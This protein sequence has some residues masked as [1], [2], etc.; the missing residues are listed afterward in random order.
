MKNESK[1]TLQHLLSRLDS[2]SREDIFASISKQYESG[3]SRVVSFLY[4]ASIAEVFWSQ[5][6]EKPLPYLASLSKSDYILPD[7]IALA[8]LYE[9]VIRAQPL[10]YLD[11]V[12]LAS[13][14]SQLSLPNH[15]G[16]DFIPAYIDYLSMQQKKIHLTLLSAYDP[17]IG[18]DAS[19]IDD[20]VS[21]LKKRFGNI[22]QVEG[23]N[24]LFSERS[25]NDFDFLWETLGSDPDT[26]YIILLATGS[27]HQEMWCDMMRAKIDRHHVLCFCAG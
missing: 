15:N 3:E 24:T 7:G 5:D 21:A 12:M 13:G 17:R 20:E 1:K 2:R 25:L 16:T 19:A 9:R 10:S 26:Y 27:P 4:F 23:Y 22:E 14:F 6:T 8:L 11:I 18:K